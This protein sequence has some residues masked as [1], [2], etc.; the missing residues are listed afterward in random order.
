MKYEDV[1]DYILLQDMFQ[2]RCEEVCGLLISLNCSYGYLSDFEIT[3]NEVWGEGDEYLGYGESEYHSAK[4]PSSFLWKDN[5]EIK[6]YVEDELNKR[7]EAEESK[8]LEIQKLLKEVQ[9]RKDRE[10][11]ERLKKKFG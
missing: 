1:Q 10:E 11:Y 8:R 6:Q 5:E 7:R 9:E 4:F 3:N 2:A